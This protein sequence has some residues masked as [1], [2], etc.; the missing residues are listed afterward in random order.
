M[1]RK[2][3]PYKRERGSA[4]QRKEFEELNNLKNTLVKMYYSPLKN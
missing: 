2:I 3:V 4:K 1:E